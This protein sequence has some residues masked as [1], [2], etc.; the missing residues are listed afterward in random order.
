MIGTSAA[1][2][3]RACI[4][5]LGDAAALVRFADRLDD[6]ANRAALA[7]ADALERSPITGVLEIAPSLVSVLVRYDSDVIDL[8]RLSGEIGLRLSSE[9]APSAAKIHDI[10]VRF[11]GEDG[12]DLLEVAAQSGLTPS[13]FIAQHNAQ[14]LRV[15]T[16]GFAPGFVYCGFHSQEMTVPRRSSVRARVPVGS[17]LFAAGQTAITAT[18][19]PT[20][21]HVIGR[22]E[23]CN[24][25]AFANPPT[26][27]SAGDNLVFS[28]L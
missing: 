20:G 23:F 10:A 16:T 22:T 3:Q 26:V 21:W 1:D 11:G 27:L 13:E 8:V 12:P 9:A 14:P 15:L 4:V 6:Q 2:V 28:A 5:P 17:V 25:N 19:V 18:E 7:L 24:F